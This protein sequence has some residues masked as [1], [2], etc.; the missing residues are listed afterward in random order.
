MNERGTVGPG[1]QVGRGM[2]IALRVG[3]VGFGGT[4]PG[5]SGPV[6]M[7]SL[8]A[9]ERYGF[10][11]AAEER[12]LSEDLARTRVQL[13]EIT[14]GYTVAS[15]DRKVIDKLRERLAADHYRDQRREDQLVIDET[16]EA[17][18]RGRRE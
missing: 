1:C 6:D 5:V 16:A 3:L 12:H 11:L 7:G 9:R 4:V 8:A 13:S 15:R 18:R 10:R 17:A 2:G 14:A